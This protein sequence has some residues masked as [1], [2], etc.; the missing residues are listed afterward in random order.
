MLQPI[1]HI[2][3]MLLLLLLFHLTL[4]PMPH[5]DHQALGSSG[6]YTSAQKKEGIYCKD[7]LLL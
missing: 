1:I 4:Q 3:R 6:K 2:P 5:E 7:L